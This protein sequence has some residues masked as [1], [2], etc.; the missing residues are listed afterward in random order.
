MLNKLFNRKPEQARDIV[1][2]MAVDYAWEIYEAL[3][4]MPNKPPAIHTVLERMEQEAREVV[5]RT[6][7]DGDFTE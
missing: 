5:E 4:T 1:T 7:N 6:W 3:R 2:S